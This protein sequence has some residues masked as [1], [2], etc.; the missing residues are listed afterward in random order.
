MDEIR[1]GLAQKWRNCLNSAERSGLGVSWTTDNCAFAEFRRRHD[2]FV[3]KKGF[4][5]DLN[6]EFFC[7]ARMK[8]ESSPTLEIAIVELDSQPVAMHLGSYVGDTATYLL[9][10]S[11]SVAHS[12]KATYLLHW[13]VIKRAHGAGLK[14]YDLGGIDPDEN[15]GVFKFKSGFGGKE[16]VSSGPMDL[17]PGLLSR[18]ALRAI[19]SVRR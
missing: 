9:G 15:P 1:R 13:E 17:Y 16:V 7:A 11:E 14:W 10:F 12:T 5:L 6:S 4:A 8:E 19:E 18:W 3:S 2:E